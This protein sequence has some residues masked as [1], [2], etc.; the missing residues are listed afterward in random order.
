M[1]IVADTKDWTWVLER[2]CT[3]CGFDST[4]VDA[5]DVAAMV[6]AQ[7]EAWAGIL[8]ERDLAWLRTPPADD[9]WSPLE[10]ACHVRDVLRLADRRVAIMLTDDDARFANWDQDATALDDAYDTQDPPAVAA[11][12]RAAASDLARR[13]DGV[14]EGAWERSGARSDGARFTVASFARYVIH[15]PLHH[16]H[17]VGAPGRG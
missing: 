4:T 7:G 1:A 16:L 14:G 6:R 17:D 12:L 9:R 3:E 2:R 11:E 13:L 15:D 8:A 10:Y 5:R